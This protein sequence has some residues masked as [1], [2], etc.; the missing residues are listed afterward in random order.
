MSLASRQRDRITHDKAGLAG[1]QT[2]RQC[3]PEGQTREDETVCTHTH[4]HTGGRARCLAS[5]LLR[6]TGFV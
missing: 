1:A 4:T 5:S 6:K 3:L 2:K